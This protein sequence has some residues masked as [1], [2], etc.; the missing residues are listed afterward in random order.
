MTTYN[1]LN[2][3]LINAVERL[4]IKRPIARIS[5]NTAKS[6]SLISEYI[7]LKKPVTEDFL[8]TFCEHYKIDYPTNN[9][10]EIL[11]LPIKEKKQENMQDE[12]DE[13]KSLKPDLALMLHNYIEA[14]K[15]RAEAERINNLAILEQS[16]SIKM[17]TELVTSTRGVNEEIGSVADNH[18]ALLQICKRHFAK[19]LNVSEETILGEYH[20]AVSSEVQKAKNM[21]KQEDGTTR[22]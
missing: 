17:L 19:L 5:E 4:G 15:I 10:L 3:W 13:S 22:N 7:N 16:S 21:D 20:T 8:R 14:G 9:E 11:E 12:K 18:H 2:I 1:K 6:K